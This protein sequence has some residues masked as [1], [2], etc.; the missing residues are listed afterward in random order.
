MGF[1][2][3]WVGWAK[4]CISTT[5]FSV[6]VNGTPAGFFNSSK[7][8]RQGD[9][10]SPYLFVLGMEAL[11]CLI[12]RAVRGGFLTSY[13]VKGRGGEG[14][15]LTHLMYA[16]DTLIFCDASKDQL[17]YLSCVLMW[18]EVI[19]G[20][21]INL[22]KSEIIPMGKVENLKVL[23]LELERKVGKLPPIYLG[24]P[25]GAPHKSVAV[26][27]GMEER[28]R[29]RLAFW[30]R[31][32]ISKGGRLTHIR[33]ALSN[34][35]IYYM[36]ILCMPISIRL[37]LEQIQRDFLWGERALE[38]KIHLVKWSVVCSDKK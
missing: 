11:S 25:L 21:R 36:S 38:R 7:G 3:K 28:L 23:A 20:L 13:R 29:R 14:V 26:W 30:K 15:Q 9:P 12:K 33:S 5:S 2:A 32:Y 10:I 18:F 4:W 16:D 8:L 6:L 22:D 31:Q 27:D 17:A 19:S 34:M 37:R 1:C 35:S 24:L